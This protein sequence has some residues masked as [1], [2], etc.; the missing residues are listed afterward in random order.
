MKAV[1]SE[2]RVVARGFHFAESPRWRDGRLYF[3]DLFGRKVY[4]LEPDGSATV[5]C[6]VPNIP[7]GLGFAPDG[8]LLIVS[9][10]D[11]KL[12]RFARGELTLAFDLAQLTPY[13]CNDLLVDD[14]GRCYI[15]NFGWHPDEPQMRLTKLLLV[16]PDGL[17]GEVGGGINFPN[18]I[19]LSA[20]GKTLIVAES[21]AGRLTAFDVAAD[22]SLSN[23]R[24]WANFTSRTFSTVPEALASKEPL[25]DGLA[26][27]SDGAVWVADSGGHCALRVAAGGKILEQVSLGDLA[28]YGLTLG[29]GDRR[30]LFLCAAAPVGSVDLQAEKTSAIFAVPVSVPGVGLP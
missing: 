14:A 11:R 30:T 25:P 20:D 13:Q 5:L 2:P 9:M 19:V 6:S 3:S 28:V 8:S 27:D 15:G 4:T 24:V 7:S 18:G 29:G 17:G 16:S 22:G 1:A 21:F 23:Q 26:M 12:L 10:S